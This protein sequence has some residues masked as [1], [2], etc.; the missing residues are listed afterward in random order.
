[1]L[2][3]ATQVTAILTLAL[4]AIA[5]AQGMRDV[6]VKTIPVSGNVYMLMGQGG[7][8]G[9]CAGDDGVFMIDDQFAPLTGRITEAIEA[10]SEEPMRCWRESKAIG[11]STS[12]TVRCCGSSRGA[13]PG[14]PITAKAA[15]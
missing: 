9:V 8:I 3:R 5:G 10:V 1:M 6:Q 2:L 14:S 7:N 12:T 4:T 13:L 15:N 11:C